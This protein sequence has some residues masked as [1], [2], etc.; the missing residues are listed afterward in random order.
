MNNL[1]LLAMFA[2]AQ[3]FNDR[4]NDLSI[5]EL[6]NDIEELSEDIGTYLFPLVEKDKNQT[7]NVAIQVLRDAVAAEKSKG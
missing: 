3:A 2:L 5:P 6:P 7:M 4:A 1:T